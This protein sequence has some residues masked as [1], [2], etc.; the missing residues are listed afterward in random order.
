MAS[1]RRLR[2]L[3]VANPAAGRRRA[4]SMA[5][6]VHRELHS[7]GAE[8]AL[9]FTGG[10]GGAE[11]ICRDALE[12][13]SPDD[14][15]RLCLVACGGDGT[16]Q[17]V[18]NALQACPD[19]AGVMGIIP[20][21]RCNDF[22]SALGISGDARGL[23]SVLLEGETRRVDLGRANGRYFCT[24]AATGF[25]AAVSRFVNEMKL[26]LRGTPAYIY[27]VL[28]VLL[29]YRP[30]NVRL[31]FDDSTVE[32]PFFLAASA[33]TSSYGGRMRI[34][35][36]ADP[37]DGML[38]ICLVSPLSR[39]RV[40]RL[41]RR[42]IRGNHADLPEVRMIRSRRMRIESTSRCEIWAD[43]ESVAV[44]PATIEAVPNALEIVLP[45]RPI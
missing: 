43:G 45:Q 29:A 17:E 8:C 6:S 22:A 3:I 18:A 1:G 39:V 11:A 44:T 12:A 7:A 24:V 16:A 20:A 36:G 4:A 42:V 15:R 13:A 14:D 5:E 10:A 41:L 37:R 30:I 38:D 9:Q 2:Y 28:R 35:P 40:L 19:R 27:G 26:P 25:D 31:T 34:A 32:G 21:G 33:N 23:A